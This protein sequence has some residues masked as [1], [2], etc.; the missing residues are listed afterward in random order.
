MDVLNRGLSSVYTFFDPDYARLSPGRHALLWQISEA[1]RRQLPYLYLGYWIKTCQKMAY[2]QE[3]RP[4]E[5]Y[6]GNHWRAFDRHT[7][8]TTTPEP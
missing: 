7:E 3:Y 6:L 5:L 8:L 1:R 2:K 4:I